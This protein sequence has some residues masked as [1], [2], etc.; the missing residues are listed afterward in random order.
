MILET[1]TCYLLLKMIRLR[2]AYRYLTASNKKLLS[3]SS[4]CLLN[5][6]TVDL[7][8]PSQKN[9]MTFLSRTL[10]RSD[11]SVFQKDYYFHRIKLKPE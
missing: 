3:S 11:L 2:I 4:C 1:V 7:T 6:T 9:H 8:M 10:F 5:F